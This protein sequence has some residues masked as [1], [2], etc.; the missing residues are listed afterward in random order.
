MMYRHMIDECLK[1]AQTELSIYK[2]NNLPEY[3]KVVE[4]RIESL[5]RI[6]K[7]APKAKFGNEL[8]VWSDNQNGDVNNSGS[9]WLSFL[10]PQRR[11]NKGV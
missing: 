3:A 9:D 2:R 1:R 6:R 5:K 7:H 4:R 8:V 10:F 11:Y